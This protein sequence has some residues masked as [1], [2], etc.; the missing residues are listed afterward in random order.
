MCTHSSANSYLRGSLRPSHKSCPE[1]ERLKPRGK[2]GTSGS[3]NDSQDNMT[4]LISEH[5]V[6]HED[7]IARVC[8]DIELRNHMTE[9]M[10][11]EK[12]PMVQ[13]GN[14]GERRESGFG[15]S[16]TTSYLQKFLALRLG[17]SLLSIIRWYGR[18]RRTG[19]YGR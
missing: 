18:G 4:T 19:R 13:V 2:T 12:D 3:N 16:H 11:Y 10:V 8:R 15:T 17:L 9:L 6:V 5:D 7:Q 1:R 14:I